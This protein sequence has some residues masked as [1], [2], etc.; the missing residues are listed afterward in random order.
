MTNR[1]V[2]FDKRIN[3]N[4]YIIKEYLSGEEDQHATIESTIPNDTPMVYS[5]DYSEETNTFQMTDYIIVSGRRIKVMFNLSLDLKIVGFIYNDLDGGYDSI[6]PLDYFRED[7]ICNTE[8]VYEAY[9]ERL[10][11]RLCE[12][13]DRQEAKFSENNSKMLGLYTRKKD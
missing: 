10:T 2:K 6:Q 11:R 3:D 13:L 7:Q 8:N 9:K 4:R 5:I 12:V 1:N